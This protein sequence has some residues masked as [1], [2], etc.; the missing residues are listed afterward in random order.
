MPRW[1]RWER[2]ETAT[3][4]RVA[5]SSSDPLIRWGLLVGYNYEVGVGVCCVSGGCDGGVGVPTL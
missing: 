1:E 2:W 5:E 4:A 3:L